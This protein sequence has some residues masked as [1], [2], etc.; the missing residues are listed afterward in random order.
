MVIDMCLVFVE[1]FKILLL[2]RFF[3]G[4]LLGQWLEET[5]PDKDCDRMKGFVEKYKEGGEEEGE[6]GDVDIVNH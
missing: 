2:I 3:T 6:E 5:S 1:A 4:L